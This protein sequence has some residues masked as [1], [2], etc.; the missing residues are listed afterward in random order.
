ME[1]TAQQKLMYAIAC[2]LRGEKISKAA[3]STSSMPAGSIKRQDADRFINLVVD[4]STLLK[5]IRVMRVDAP[6][7]SFSKLN[8]SGPVTRVATEGTDPSDTRK[9]TNTVVSYAVAKTI[10]CLDITGEAVEDNPEGDSGRTTI[11]DAMVSQI[12]NDMENLAIEGDSSISG[13]TDPELLLKANDGYIKLTASGTG[14]HQTDATGLAPSVELLQEMMGDLPTKYR[15]DKSKLRW[16]M[17]ENTALML[18]AQLANTGNA[19]AYRGALADMALQDGGLPKIHG[20]SALVVPLMP[21]D[22]TIDGTAGSTGAVIWL[23]DPN[24]LIYVVQRDINV[25]WDRRPRIDTDQCTIT[26]RTD[27]VVEN[28]DAVVRATNVNLSGTVNFYGVS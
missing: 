20:V 22:L 4:E 3:F 19:N 18:S 14:A 28:T 26:M 6:S 9:P 2:E 21:E 1:L 13:V 25:E 27:F 11:L 23:T 17:S 10:S 15:K 16:I 8:I 7:G 24:N 12:G 5:N